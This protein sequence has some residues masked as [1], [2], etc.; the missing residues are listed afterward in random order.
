VNIAMILKLFYLIIKFPK[1]H[2]MTKGDLWCSSSHD[3]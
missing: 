1:D 2:V 3:F